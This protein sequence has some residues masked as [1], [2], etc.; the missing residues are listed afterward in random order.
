MER[1]VKDGFRASDLKRAAPQASPQTWSLLATKIA[2][3]IIVAR[4]LPETLFVF[5]ISL[6][7][8]FLALFFISIFLLLFLAAN[9]RQD[10]L[11]LVKDRLKNL[12]VELIKEYYE[13]KTDEELARW[14]ERLLERR[15]D[16]KVEL[17]NGLNIRGSGQNS[18][19][20][21][22]INRTW[23][24]LLAVIGGRLERSL[25]DEEISSNLDKLIDKENGASQ[26][27]G[28]SAAQDLQ[29]GDQI[30]LND[31]PEY[32]GAASGEGAENEY[33]SSQN[34]K[35]EQLWDDDI[36]P[37]DLEELPMED[38]Q[39]IP[40]AG[41]GAADTVP[42]HTMNDAAREVE[43]S[44]DSDDE[45]HEPF[46]LELDVASP[47]KKETDDGTLQ[48]TKDLSNMLPDPNPTPPVQPVQPIQPAQPAEPVAPTN[49]DDL[50]LEKDGISYIDGAALKTHAASH[51]GQEGEIN[52]KLKGLIEEVIG[53]SSDSKI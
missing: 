37:E 33:G 24:E 29:D 7:I 49:E 35:A 20:D 3:E 4:L 14:G 27:A 28:Q 36:Q 13:H 42:S 8:L 43:F 47:F 1:R 18:E 10:P 40:N 25:T 48:Y 17:K 22:W 31:K 5:P 19:L 6:K 26:S 16:I 34:D 52:P 30:P 11:T 39:I 15:E 46:A 41:S 51:T 53:N 50:I 45:N 32:S 2:Q 9:I 23:D 44:L 12:Q 21:A 38:V